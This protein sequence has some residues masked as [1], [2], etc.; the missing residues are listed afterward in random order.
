V[1]TRADDLYDLLMPAVEALGYDLWGIELMGSGRRITLR[2]YIDRDEGITVDDCAL[3]S[4]QV[5]SELDVADP[6]QGE[7]TLEVSSPGWDRPLFRPEQYSSYIGSLVKARF[8]VTVGGRRACTGRLVAADDE[9]AVFDVADLE[10]PLRVP[11]ASIRKAQIVI[12]D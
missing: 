5:S 2:V 1:S 3:V 11:F 10:E 7:Y 9:A 4:R 8:Y 6:I 12:E